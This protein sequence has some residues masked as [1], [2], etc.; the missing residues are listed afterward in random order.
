M[1]QGNFSIT[2]THPFVLLFFDKTPVYNTLQGYSYCSDYSP[3]N[4]YSKVPV[5]FQIIS[6]SS[7]R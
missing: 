4:F 1:C 2:L 6:G 7:G 5:N 3:L